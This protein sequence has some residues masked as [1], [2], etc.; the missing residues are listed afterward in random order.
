MREKITVDFGNCF[1][2]HM[3]MEQVFLVSDFHW[4]SHQPPVLSEPFNYLLLF[5]L[6][7]LGRHYFIVC[8]CMCACVSFTDAAVHKNNRTRI[9]LPTLSF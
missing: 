4:V 8:L 7:P 3:T 5:P 9:V 6:A 2:L 1:H